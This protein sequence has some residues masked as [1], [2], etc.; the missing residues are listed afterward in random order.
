M[1][2]PRFAIA[3][4]AF[5]AFGLAW[6]DAGIL[7]TWMHERTAERTRLQIQRAIP[8]AVEA[9]PPPIIAAAMTAVAA[10]VAG[11]RRAP[12]SCDLDM[13]GLPE[14]DRRVYAQAR[15]IPAGETMTYGQIA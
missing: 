15:T 7:R 11:E 12:V 10:L 3:E 1:T 9:P 8:H 13:T 4:N 2:P 5:G 6:T 14:F